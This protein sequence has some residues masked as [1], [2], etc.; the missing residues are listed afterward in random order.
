MLLESTRNNECCTV[1]IMCIFTPKLSIQQN[2][3]WPWKNADGRAGWPTATW[4]LRVTTDTWW[5]SSESTLHYKH[6]LDYVFQN[7]LTVSNHS[8]ATLNEEYSPYVWTGGLGKVDAH[9]HTQ[10]RALLGTGTLGWRWNWGEAG[11][12]MKREMSFKWHPH[13]EPE[14]D[15]GTLQNC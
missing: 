4:P 10:T 9:T 12:K 14:Q 8:S 2:N 5:K 13:C 6:R 15:D 11:A 1:S 7:R 3:A